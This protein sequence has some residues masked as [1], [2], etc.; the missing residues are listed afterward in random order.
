MKK[1]VGGIAVAVGLMSTAA[2]GMGTVATIERDAVEYVKAFDQFVSGDVSRMTNREIATY[3]AF[4]GA[5]DGSIAAMKMLGCVPERDVIP[6]IVDKDDHQV[7]IFI[8]STIVN[9]RNEGKLNPSTRNTEAIG[10]VI[11]LMY[12]CSNRSGR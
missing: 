5:Y 3:A 10:Y 2:F 9:I 8:L 1:I 4:A 11:S 12:D 6:I 7:M